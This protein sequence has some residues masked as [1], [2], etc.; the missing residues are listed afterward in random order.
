[1]SEEEEMIVSAKHCDNPFTHFTNEYL[2]IA[3]C[4][5]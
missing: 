4:A 5:Y 1:V 3:M 2:S